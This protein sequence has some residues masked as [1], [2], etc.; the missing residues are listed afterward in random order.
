MTFHISEE[1]TVKQV[2]RFLGWFFLA[3]GLISLF[4][5]PISG[6]VFALWGILLLPITHQFA[7]SR[8][9][10][11]EWW[12]CWIIAIVG[13]ILIAVATPRESQIVNRP[14]PSSPSPSITKSAKPKL[15]PKPLPRQ[16]PKVLTP[17]QRAEMFRLRFYDEVDQRA[18]GIGI[19]GKLASTT[20]QNWEEQKDGVRLGFEQ[21]CTQMVESPDALATAE[22]AYRANERTIPLDQLEVFYESKYAAAKAIGCAE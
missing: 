19:K 18:T 14:T 11:L 7:S 8:T 5:N 2:R 16:S 17:D 13:F 22:S 4:Y 21:T 9:I 15:L 20:M 6:I 10:A 1:L 3:L 12:K